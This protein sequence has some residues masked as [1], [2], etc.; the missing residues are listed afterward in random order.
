MYASINC[1]RIECQYNTSTVCKQTLYSIEMMLFSDRT[2]IFEIKY[3][4]IYLIFQFL[5]KR[6][7]SP[8]QNCVVQ[9]IHINFR[10]NMRT[11]NIASLNALHFQM[12]VESL[13]NAL[14]ACQIQ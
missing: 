3:I 7:K 11:I 9:K 2:R 4:K 8:K 12:C 6:M 14:F 1:H 5:F 10:L 13:R